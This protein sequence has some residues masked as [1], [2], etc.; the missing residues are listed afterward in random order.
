MHLPTQTMTVFLTVISV[1]M[2]HTP[3]VPQQNPIYKRGLVCLFHCLPPEQNQSLSDQ[4]PAR[5]D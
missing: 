5:P 2:T 3:T 1:K 4:R